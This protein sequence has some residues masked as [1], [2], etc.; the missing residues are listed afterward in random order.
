MCLGEM[1]QYGTLGRKHLSLSELCET[2]T[3]VHKKQTNLQLQS[4][5]L[6]EI[7]HVE[8][9][10]LKSLER[11]FHMSPVSEA[12]SQPARWLANVCGV[13]LREAKHI[14]DG[15]TPLCAGHPDEWLNRQKGALANQQTI[16]LLSR[17]YAKEA[18]WMHQNKRMK[19]M[20]RG[21]HG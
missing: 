21:E 2:R 17:H 8:R 15:P 16:S 10:R 3:Q 14:V 20:P 12:D 6:L 11:V 19:M 1:H 13:P 4:P 5:W 7:P 9:W 18:S